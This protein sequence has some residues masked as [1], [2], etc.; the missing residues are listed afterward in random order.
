MSN[1]KFF[2]HTADIGVEITGRT[3]K[4]LFVNAAD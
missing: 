3:R 2:D 4:G 1:Y